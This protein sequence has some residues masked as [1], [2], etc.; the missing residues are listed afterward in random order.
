M[1]CSGEHQ[2]SLCVCVSVFICDPTDFLASSEK[3][4]PNDRSCFSVLWE[5]QEN[6]EKKLLGMCG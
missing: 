5:H 4:Q 2:K 1:H 3:A 6:I